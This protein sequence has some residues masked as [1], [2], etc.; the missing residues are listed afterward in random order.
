MQITLTKEL[1]A[2]FIPV[3]EWMGKPDTKW[4][5]EATEKLINTDM[6]D[7]ETI[8]TFKNGNV[9]LGEYA[10][11]YFIVATPEGEIL[12]IFQVYE[13]SNF[14]YCER[15]DAVIMPGHEDV[16]L[17]YSDGTYDE[18]HTR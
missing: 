14:E 18:T 10:W 11:N 16:K 9:L 5:D 4:F 6:S 13:P 15:V 3:P 2:K 12:S 1:I 7:V 17:V 8:Y